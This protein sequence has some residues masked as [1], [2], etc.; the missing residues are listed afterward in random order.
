MLTAKE[1]L[2]LNILILTETKGAPAQVGYDLSVKEI[3]K[4]S[5]SIQNPGVVY[6]DSTK[7]KTR[8]PTGISLDLIS[9]PAGRFY[10][11]SPG[12]YE[13]VFWEGCNLPLNCTGKIRQRSSLLRNGAVISSSIFDPGFSTK[14]IGTIMITSLPFFYIEE[15]SRLAQFYVQT[16]TPVEQ[17]Y[18]GQFQGDRQRI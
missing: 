8:L 4:L 17:G 18:D 2:D 3:R 12:V 14:N 9:L 15:D 7:N 6:K 16:N 13:L 10:S 5:F 11:I 1:I